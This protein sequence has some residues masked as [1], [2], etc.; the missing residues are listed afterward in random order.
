MNLHRNPIV[1]LGM[2]R[3]GTSALAGALYRLGVS[4]GR[5]SLLYQGDANNAGGYYEH[6]KATILNLRTLRT[7][8]MHPTSLGR[9]PEGWKEHPQAESLRAEL[10]GFIET[11]FANPGRWAIKQPVTS[12]VIPLYTDVFNELAIEPHYVICVR[13]PLECMASESKLD[14]G[15]SYRVMA[16]LGEAAVGSWLRYTL[17]AFADVQGRRHLTVVP[18]ADFLADPDTSLRAIVDEHPDWEPSRQQ[19]VEAMSSIKGDLR[20]NRVTEQALDSYPA[21]V[22]RTFRAASSFDPSN[23]EDWRT[24]LGLYREYELWI[25]MM[26]EPATPPGKLGLAWIEDGRQRISEVRYAPEGSWQTI[27]LPI[28]APPKTVVS[29][30]LYGRPYR[31]WIRKCVWN[32]GEKTA[33]AALR[34]GLGSSIERAGPL[35]LLH[36]VFEPNQ[37]ALTTPAGP[38]PYDLEIEMFLEV[39]PFVSEEIAAGLSRKLEECVLSVERLGSYP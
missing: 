35:S 12:M 26:S 11:E 38:G 23:V 17:G 36:G 37:I 33:P 29:G 16:S 4:F 30:L 1:I 19:W 7:F 5:E 9:L 8:Q 3:S 2:Q 13:N 20:H 6:R 32:I 31:A 27:R 39:G 21:L 18:Y 22:G 24:I 34:T 10:R 25:S 28:D 14:F 15:D